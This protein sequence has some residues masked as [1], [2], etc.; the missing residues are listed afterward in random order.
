MTNR[1]V[2]VLR[3]L[4]V[5]LF[6]ALL[7]GQ[8]LSIPGQLAFMASQSP[9]FAPLRWPLL[10]VGGLALVVLA[11]ARRLPRI[12]PPPAPR[13]TASASAKGSFAPAPTPSGRGWS[14]S[15]PRPRTPS[16]PARATSC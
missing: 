5:L 8:T 7:V 2:V 10:V 12:T 9:V 14:A 11:C 13:D 16:A 1:A 6:V 3:I 15:G 4:L